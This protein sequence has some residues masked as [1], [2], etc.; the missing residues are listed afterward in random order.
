[1]YLMSNLVTIKDI[2]KDYLFIY[3]ERVGAHMSW[4]GEGQRERENLKQARTAHRA[5]CR[6]Q[7]QDPEIMT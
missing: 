7:S 5:Q 3:L 2:F 4:G 1:L 6:A